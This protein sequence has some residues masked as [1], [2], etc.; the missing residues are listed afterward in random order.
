MLFDR[1]GRQAALSVAALLAALPADT[2]VVAYYAAAGEDGALS[3][4]VIDTSGIRFDEL[5]IN[6]AQLDSRVRAL[7]AMLSNPHRY[8]DRA[9]RT[10]AAALSAE[11]LPRDWQRFDSIGQRKLFIVPT[12]TLHLLPFGSLVDQ[13]GRFLDEAAP[14]IAYLPNLSTMRIAA[15]S[16]PRAARTAA[17]INPALDADHHDLLEPLPALQQRFGTAF[18]RWS[19]GNL[20]WETPWT[21]DDFAAQAGAL[22][23]VFLFAHAR[24]LPADP[25]NSY[26]RL[27][28]AS[29]EASRLTARSIMRSQVGDGLWV[30][31]ACSTGGGRVRPGDE[32][33]GLPRALIEA[34]ARAA[35]ISLWDVEARSS[36]E[37]MTRFYENLGNGASIA[38]ALKAATSAIRAQGKPPY[39]W[40]P[41][42]LVGHHDFRRP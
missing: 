24:F 31:A 14:L 37:L 19:G 6:S 41:F 25:L 32:V 8:D 20:R 17:F 2:A 28:G 40:A 21:P 4:A 26:V 29:D 13:Q 42:V 9:Y 1:D 27:A 36:L 22:D 18:T 5:T 16:P 15:A 38:A 11:L 12:G 30:L 3:R 33:L 39:D 23:N 34:G 7:L 35:L 10:A